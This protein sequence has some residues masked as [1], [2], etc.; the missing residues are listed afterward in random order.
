MTTPKAQI[1]QLQ[2]ANRLLTDDLQSLLS[3]VLHHQSATRNLRDQLRTANARIEELER[4]QTR[5]LQ[6]DGRAKRQ[7]NAELEGQN[8]ALRHRVRE[9]E[10]EAEARSAPIR[11]TMRLTPK[12]EQQRAR[13]ARKMVN[14]LQR[15]GTA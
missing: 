7:A 3:D 9:L 5:R 15:Q 2:Y 8:V 14:R 4:L 13:C 1:A 10:S 11:L 12:Q 6:A